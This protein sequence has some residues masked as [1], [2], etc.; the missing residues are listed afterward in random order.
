MK[1][2]GVVLLIF[3]GVGWF[4]LRTT[5]IN[6]PETPGFE[7]LRDDAL[8]QRYAPSII[9]PEEFDQPVALYYRAARSNGKQY[10]TY[11]FVWAGETNPAP[12]FFPWLNRSLY[13]GGLRLQKIMFGKGDVE[14]VSL[15]IDAAGNLD[16]VIYET[17]E[18]HDPSDFGV[19]HSTVRTVAKPP[20]VFEVVS[21]NHLFLLKDSADQRG[22]AR[23]LRPEYFTQSLWEEYEMVKE[24]ETV[25]KRSRAHQAYE[26]R[27][28][29]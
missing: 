13:T 8:A 25:L 23:L 15:V 12:G 14:M 7:P 28:A 29:P 3:V 18:N 6:S 26:R 1:K 5:R 17:A 21:W 2:W 19:K 24:R 22:T 11:H 27:A 4:L 20:L 16:E 9:S 10:I